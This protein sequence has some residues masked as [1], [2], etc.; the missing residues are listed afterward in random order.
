MRKTWQPKPAAKRPADADWSELTARDVMQRGLVTVG[1]NAPL[2]EVERVLG[3]QRISGVPVTDRS[4]HIVGVLSTRDLLERYAEDPD[5][6]P[7]KV[8]A[9][10]AAEREAAAEDEDAPDLEVNEQSTLTAGD[11]MNPEVFAVP[12]DASLRDVAK[13]MIGHN[14]HRIL[15][16]EDGRYIGLISAFDLLRATIA[17]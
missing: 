8:P 15:V 4:G 14:V 16:Q 6:R 17:K 13:S 12:V 7:Q 9:F 5:A 3:D 10:D 2:A 1:I 11:V